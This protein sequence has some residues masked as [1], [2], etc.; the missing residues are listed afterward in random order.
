MIGSLV[1]TVM[2]FVSTSS[3][4]AAFDFKTVDTA[5]LHSMI[6]DNAYRLEG[7]REKHFTVIDARTKEEYDDYHIFSAI[8]VPAG[9]FEGSAK[10]LPKD[11]SELLIVY[12]NDARDE[13]CRKWA[14]KASSAGYTNVAVYSEGIQL[15]K[16][17]KMPIA[18]LRSRL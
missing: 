3:A 14:A 18:P 1:L 4:V 16:E 8:S 9:R 6:V 2:I 5:E 10:L 13:T 12:G 7:G 17:K 11:K 15:W